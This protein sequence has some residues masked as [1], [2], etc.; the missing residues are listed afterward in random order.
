MD[1]ILR[2]LSKLKQGAREFQ[3]H[4]FSDTELQLSDETRDLVRGLE[5]I[6]LQDDTPR[7]E[8]EWAENRIALRKLM[9]HSDLRFFLRWQVIRH[10]MFP[11]EAPYTSRELRYLRKRGV[12][13]NHIR[14]DRAGHPDGLLAYPWTSGNLIHLEYHLH[15]FEDLTGFD[16]AGIDF[17]LEFGGGYGNL[18]RLIHRREFSGAYFIYDLPEL[19][20]LQRYYLRSVGIEAQLVGQDVAPEQVPETG[21]FLVSD[22]ATLERCL[23]KKRTQSMFAATWSLSETPVAFRA[24]FLQ[25]AGTFDYYLIGYQDGFNEVNNTV[26]FQEF[27]DQRSETSWATRQLPFQ[28]GN[29]Y[30]AGTP[31]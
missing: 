15:Q 2:Q 1:F 26:Y 17:L 3:V 16:P 29:Y 6:Q 9:T 18:C 31:K 5:P 25:C 11:A 13:D 20:I 8:V 19:S 10:T 28:H 30:L 4:S 27:V 12:S 24:E 7:S 23:Q 21:I 22:L 14:E